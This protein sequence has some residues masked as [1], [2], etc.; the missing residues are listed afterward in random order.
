MFCGRIEVKDLDGTRGNDNLPPGGYVV[1]D[2]GSGGVRRKFYT[3]CPEWMGRLRPE[4]F[5]DL[6]LASGETFT[7]EKWMVN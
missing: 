5:C 3:R 4:D 7:N 1:P 2:G 6:G